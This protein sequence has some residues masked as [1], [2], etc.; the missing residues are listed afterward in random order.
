[1]SSALASL[2]QLKIA[3]LLPLMVEEKIIGLI[4]VGQKESNDAY[5]QGD[6][7]FLRVVSIQA[8][9]ALNNALLYEKTKLYTHR[10]KEEKNKTAAIITNLI[11]PIIVLDNRGK[12][13]LF[14][15]AA[16]LK[17]GFNKT[18]ILASIKDKDDLSL[19]SFSRFIRARHETKII[20]EDKRAQTML[21]EIVINPSEKLSYGESPFRVGAET[22]EK[23]EFTYKVQSTP[24]I[25]ED[26]KNIGYMKIIFLGIFYITQVMILKKVLYR[27]YIRLLSISM[28]MRSKSVLA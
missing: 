22:Q 15:R 9:L 20:E 19:K 12:I 10:L 4:I 2:K 28:K 23:D 14:N 24:I 17:L 7:D 6:L 25:D 27:A 5:N 13:L 3:V 8:A 1:M 11:D 26:G 21:E 16:E 18:D